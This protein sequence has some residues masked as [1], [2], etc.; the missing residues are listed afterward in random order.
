MLHFLFSSTAVDFTGTV[1]NDVTQI[2][3]FPFEVGSP[4]SCKTISV[5][6]D[7]NEEIDETFTISISTSNAGTNVLIGNP[8]AL[9]FTIIDDGRKFF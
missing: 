7:E 4:R 6:D 2:T 1:T 5:F 3:T 8:S 9:T